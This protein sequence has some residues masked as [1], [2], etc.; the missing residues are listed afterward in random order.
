MEETSVVCEIVISQFLSAQW[1]YL[2]GVAT[3]EV[4]HTLNYEWVFA[5]ILL[6]LLLSLW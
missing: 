1:A 3:E 6:V 4:K 5:I 2:K